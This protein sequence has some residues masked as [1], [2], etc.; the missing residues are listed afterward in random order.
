MNI[1]DHPDIVSAMKT[2]YPSWN[3][4][5]ESRPYCEECGECLED[6][7]L[8]YDESHNCLCRKCLLFLH[9]KSWW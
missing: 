6:E 3:Q 2:G 7:D 5:D 8:Y 4:P 1:P 9:E